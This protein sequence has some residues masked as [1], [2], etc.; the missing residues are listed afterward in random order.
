MRE[1]AALQSRAQSARAIRATLFRAL[2]VGI[3]ETD[4]RG[5]VVA[6]NAEAVAQ[7]GALGRDAVLGGTLG[8]LFWPADRR[9]EL[10]ES[11]A[12]LA[13][14]D[15]G[16]KTKR[17]KIG[18]REVLLR[19]TRRVVRGRDGTVS[20][21]LTCREELEDE[22]DRAGELLRLTERFEL[23]FRHSSH[24]IAILDRALRVTEV[25]PAAERLFGWDAEVYGTSLPA[26]LPTAPT[27]PSA[28]FLVDVTRG[29]QVVRFT[30]ALKGYGERGYVFVAR[31]DVARPSDEELALQAELRHA[32][33]LASIGRLAA[34]VA[35]EFCDLLTA[36]LLR[37]R[38][39]T[40]GTESEKL[41]RGFEIVD[42]AARRGALLSRQ[43]LAF[44]Q[45]QSAAPQ[46]VEL[47]SA[48]SD[49]APLLGRLAGP[50][51]EV[52]VHAS[53]RAHIAL[54][55]TQLEQVVVNLVAN[56]RDA[57]VGRGAI[58]VDMAIAGDEVIVSVGDDG[59]GI[60]PDDV[61]R[62]F[63]RFVTKKS[64]STGLGLATVYSIAES[65]GGRVEVESV[66]GEGSV[67]RVVLPL[68]DQDATEVPKMPSDIST[69]AAGAQVAL[70]E[71][72]AEVRELAGATLADAG[73][74]VS[75][76][77]RW[78]ALRAG[79]DVVIAEH[80][81]LR[82]LGNERDA[83]QVQVDGD[84]TVE[85]DSSLVFLCK[86]YSRVELLA[87]V[88]EALLRRAAP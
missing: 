62:I 66:Q 77:S 54:Q 2:P 34:G 87:A 52:N 75:T 10:A 45:G 73:Y 48:L 13:G 64:A 31:E 32:Q 39:A 56:A 28:R 15:L 8:E 47:Q 72:D 80:D 37:T 86:P 41:Q 5:V 4:M 74:V 9:Q 49:L 38:R 83:A 30:G 81:A 58:S 40:D 22:R 71:R 16:A 1:L 65:N 42:S 20:G 3:L 12:T 88:R 25:N 63:D 17:V 67:F 69:R 50:E 29:T 57:I 33:R 36:I 55:L 6:V 68:S 14:A 53:E 24:P 78:E 18:R 84:A 35:R 85:T 59:V 70:V 82:E 61:V 27:S 43:L 21:L 51:I 76:A 44:D 26:L 11:Y 19:T 46:I 79:Y 7:L 23:V 60:D